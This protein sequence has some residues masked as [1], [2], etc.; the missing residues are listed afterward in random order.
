MNYKVEFQR[1]FFLLINNE[2][3]L[4]K[5]ITGYKNLG[6]LSRPECTE[7]LYMWGWFLIYTETSIQIHSFLDL[8][9]LPVNT[10]NFLKTFFLFFRFLCC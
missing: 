3:K 7:I 10:G 1:K 4:I 2:C 5:D 9:G 8:Q 6:L